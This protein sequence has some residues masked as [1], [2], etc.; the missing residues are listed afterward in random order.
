MSS[1]RYIHGTD[2]DEQ[3]R[4]SRLNDRL[5]SA[6]L[7]RLDLRTGM[8]VLDVGSGLG[9]MARAIARAVSPGGVVVGVE[10]DA[11]QRAAAERLA[12]EAAEDRLVEFRAG[13]AL[14]LPLGPSETGSFDLVFC[15][16]VLEHLR[17]PERAVAEMVRAARPGGVIA[18]A[19][20]D[21]GLC[22]VHPPC[23]EFEPVWSAYRRAYGALGLDERVGSRLPELLER[24]GARARGCD[25]IFFGGCHGAPGWEDLVTNVVEVVRTA[26]ADIVAGALMQGEPFDRGLR[27]LRE[28]SGRPGAAI[29]FPVCWAWGVR[30]R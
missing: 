12:R 10:R 29:W 18:L 16:Y 30:P 11:A 19:D 22:H 23:P 2:P 20:D 17:E 25:F 14:A 24:A 13:D 26:R 9:Q 5:N 15:R 21:H 28:W 6:C 3:A 8:R 7:A 1:D 27:A 4:L